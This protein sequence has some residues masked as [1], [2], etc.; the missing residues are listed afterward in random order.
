MFPL[1]S[2]PWTAFAPAGTADG[3]RL[4]GAVLSWRALLRQARAV[5]AGEGNDLAAS[6]DGMVSFITA[7]VVVG[8]AVLIGLVANVGYNTREK[9]D[10]QH[11]ADSIAISGATWKARGMNAV[12]AANHLMGEL[13][14]LCVMHYSFGGP[15]LDDGNEVS[16]QEKSNGEMQL[17]VAA[18]L[19]SGDEF[20]S[21]I[22]S[23]V[24]RI[25]NT[26]WKSGATIYDARMMLMYVEYLAIQGHIIAE[27]VQL[28]PYVGEF[29]AMAIDL[30]CTALRFKVTQEWISLQ[31]LEGAVQAAVQPRKALESV[32]LPLIQLYA[33]TAG[34]NSPELPFVNNTAAAADKA[35]KDLEQK[36][37]LKK[38]ALFPFPFP[39]TFKLPIERE[40]VPSTSGGKPES[41]NTAGGFASDVGKMLHLLNVASA[42]RSALSFFFPSLKGFD[43]PTLD[44]DAL[45]NKGYQGNPSRDKLPNGDWNKEQKSQFVRATYPWVNYWRGPV[46]NFMDLTL[47]LS[48]SS[49]WYLYW[50]DRYT[51]AK[52]HEFRTRSSKKLAM[53]VMT[54]SEKYG[55]G[56]EPWTKES[57]SKQADQLFCVLG[58]AQ[59][60]AK[61]IAM[62]PVFGKP[63]QNSNGVVAFAQAMVYNANKQDASANPGDFQPEIG[64][65]TLNWRSPINGSNAYEFAKG[66][67]DPSAF[68]ALKNFLNN[69]GGD[70]NQP[71]IKLNWQARLTPVSR[72]FNEPSIML[73]LPAEHRDA[74]LPFQAMHYV[75]GTKMFVNH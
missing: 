46:R 55:K 39:N 21:S 12:T 17:D 56:K 1:T 72:L 37:H 36:N 9:Q 15:E 10:M 29:L 38:A 23:D 30:A 44:Q 11:R 73:A 34:G 32:V 51:L 43:M 64:W 65:N 2:N 42:A 74:L 18:D 6:E 22:D 14:A 28:I 53:Y 4:P 66:V 3:S 61:T 52:T 59:R 60:P 58:F 69:D 47:T 68:G 41:P 70:D 63:Q 40:K 71:A 54:D 8:F 50:S 20:K 26:K 16:T 19:A 25:K 31:L 75:T 33:D 27:V 45:G 48:T 13:T 7:L 35:T 24:Q 5:L 57:G 62:V 49:A 67:K